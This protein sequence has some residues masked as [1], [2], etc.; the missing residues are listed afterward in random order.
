M[1][2]LQEYYRRLDISGGGDSPTTTYQSVRS[3]NKNADSGV[4][5]ASFQPVYQIVP[6][7]QHDL[8]AFYSADIVQEWMLELPAVAPL[9]PHSISMRSLF[10]LNTLLLMVLMCGL[11]LYL[12]AVRWWFLKR[13]QKSKNASGTSKPNSKEN[14]DERTLNGEPNEETFLL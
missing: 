11:M 5:Q 10:T 14:R 1:Y 6:D 8:V 2:Y 3:N 13:E 4:K 9:K 7:L 12:W